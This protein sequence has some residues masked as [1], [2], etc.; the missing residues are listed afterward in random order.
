M[1]LVARRPRKSLCSYY[2]V[3]LTKLPSGLP[4]QPKTAA[5]NKLGKT[6]HFKVAQSADSA[7][8]LAC[9][10]VASSRFQAW[11]PVRMTGQ[12]SRVKCQAPAC[13]LRKDS[14]QS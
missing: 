4:F 8:L 12:A 13:K 10:P 2:A 11:G 3:K 9:A 6:C 7:E 1:H 5:A 14:P